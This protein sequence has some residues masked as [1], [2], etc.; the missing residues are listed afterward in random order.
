MNFTGSSSV[1]LFKVIYLYISGE[2]RWLCTLLLQQG[3]RVD[4]SAAADA[5]TYCPESFDEFFN[6]RRRWVP[7]TLANIWDLLSDFNNTVLIND[8]ISRLFMI[9]QGFLMV[10]T[11]L[12]PSTIVITIASAFQSV[13]GLENY[14]WVAY[15]L[16][17]L[18]PALYLAICFIFEEKTQLMLAGLFSMIYAAIMTIVLVGLVINIAVTD[19]LNPSLFFLIFLVASFILAGFLHPYEMFC[20]LHGILYFICIPTGY[21]LLMIYSLSN[22]HVISWGTREVPQRKSQK[23]QAAEAQ[24]P[25]PAKK[26]SGFVA[27]IR[28]IIES[29]L[30]EVKKTIS[31]IFQATKQDRSANEKMVKMLGDIRKELKRLNRRQAGRLDSSSSSDSE[32]QDTAV[33]PGTVQAIEAPKPEESAQKETPPPEQAVNLEV[34]IECDP[35]NPKWIQDPGLGEGGVGMINEREKAFWDNLI[36]KYLKPL[37]SDKRQKEKLQADLIAVRNNVS[38]GFWM[39]NAIWVLLNFMLQTHISP[40]N[41]YLKDDG[42]WITC[43][44]HGF[45]FIVFY[46]IVLGLQILGM[47]MH[48]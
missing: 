13:L 24:A 5:L 27:Y 7:S 32:D 46:L 34:V 8:N 16:S 43:Q 22:M 4:Y 41:L 36:K 30:F 40:I 35:D 45:V 23:Q 18:I 2:D 47:L 26:K 12:G 9:Y 48:R 29:S 39:V 14:L 10:S 28:R 11:V 20:L 17:L 3:Y 37:K 6:Q 31:D 1:I 15:T 25:K 38:F 42:T 21:V 19:V 44:P 33:L